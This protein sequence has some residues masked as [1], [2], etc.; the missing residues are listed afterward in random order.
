MFYYIAG[1]SELHWTEL[2]RICLNA[3]VFAFVDSQIGLGICAETTGRAFKVLCV[4]VYSA[5][6][7][8]CT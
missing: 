3:T 8:D 4:G 5:M 6:I 7:V 2:T 1:C